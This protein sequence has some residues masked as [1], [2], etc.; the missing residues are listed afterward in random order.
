MS[1]FDANG[2]NIRPFEGARL[3]VE[4]NGLIDSANL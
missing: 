3:D 1:F 4:I 2:F